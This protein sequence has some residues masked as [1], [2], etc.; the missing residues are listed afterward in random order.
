MIEL[1]C[2]MGNQGPAQRRKHIPKPRV[3]PQ[4]N[5]SWIGIYFKARR[6]RE[7]FSNPMYKRMIDLAE[8]TQWFEL[9]AVMNCESSNE[10]LIC[11]QKTCLGSQTALQ[12]IE[13]KDN[14]S[15]LPGNVFDVPNSMM[16]VHIFCP[17][18]FGKTKRFLLGMIS[19]LFCASSSVTLKDQSENLPM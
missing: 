2:R 9:I 3:T 19:D 15:N 10:P 11:H 18:N 12:P 13:G 17:V 16:K 7:C 6:R 5:G 4:W 14:V 1:Q 8:F